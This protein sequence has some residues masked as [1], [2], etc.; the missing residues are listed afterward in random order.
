MEIWKLTIFAAVWLAIIYFF[1]SL[2]AKR[3]KIIDLKLAMLYFATVAMVGV[4]G[5]I[6]LDT[7]YNFFVGHPLWRYNI[8]PIQH[9]YTSAYAVMPWGTVGFYLYLMHDHLAA[10]WSITRTRYL[11]LIFSVEALILEA[12]V[13]LSARMFFGKYLY[14]YLPGDLW[15][16]S[17][18]QN[19]PF[20]YICGAAIVQIIKRFKT[21]PYFFTAMS[22]FLIFVLVYIAK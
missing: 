3:F 5:E 2:V 7:V 21:D 1:N 9:G 20:Y 11:S 18:L 17:T 6:F 10:R 22:I 8:L 14:Y 12:A 13:T 16:V 4:Y 15:H 19:L